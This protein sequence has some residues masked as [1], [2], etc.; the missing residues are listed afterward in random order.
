MD[1]WQGFFLAWLGLSGAV[2][3]TT[4]GPVDPERHLGQSHC[5]LRGAP[6]TVLGDLVRII[7]PVRNASSVVLEPLNFRAVL[8]SLVPSGRAGLGTKYQ[9]QLAQLGLSSTS[10][11]YGACSVHSPGWCCDLLVMRGNKDGRLHMDPKDAL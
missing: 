2:C 8:S 3:I 7:A 9:Y 5:V 11:R 1:T 10:A 4:D 6:L